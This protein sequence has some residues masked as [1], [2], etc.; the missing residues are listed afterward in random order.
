MYRPNGLLFLQ[1]SLDIGP[2]LVEKV[3]EEGPISPVKKLFEYP[4]IIIA[5][6]TVSNMNNSYTSCCK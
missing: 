2:I 6:L 5:P 4:P 1:K 3:L